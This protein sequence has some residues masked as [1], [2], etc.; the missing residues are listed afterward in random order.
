MPGTRLGG[1]KARDKIL[2]RYGKDHYKNMGRKGGLKNNGHLGFGSLE[3][4]KD[5]LTGQQRARI[6][7]AIGGRISKRGCAKAN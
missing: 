3:I 6:A 5:G 7:G 2:E 4:G 1:L